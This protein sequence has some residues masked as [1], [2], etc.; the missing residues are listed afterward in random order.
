M[1]KIKILNSIVFLNT[2]N[3][4]FKNE[5]KQKIN[6]SNKNKIFRNKFNKRSIRLG[7]WELQN[8][9]ERKLNI[10]SIKNPSW[11]CRNQQIDPKIY[12]EMGTHGSQ[13]K[14]WKR[15]KLEDIHFP[16]SK[17][18]YKATVIMSVWY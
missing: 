4:K 10:I 8:F 17:T 3:E 9:V 1:I 5:I 13:T 12:M 15:T 16:I 18:Y 7:H 11:F 14:F 2:S 6:N